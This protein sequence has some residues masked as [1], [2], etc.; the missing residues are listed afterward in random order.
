[1]QL[2]ALTPIAAAAVALIVAAANVDARDVGAAG[3]NTL[4]TSRRAHLS[5]PDLDLETTTSLADAMVLA[6]VIQVRVIDEPDLLLR[7]EVT[8][9]VAETYFGDATGDITVQYA[10]GVTATRSFFVPGAP[11]LVGGE[12]GV[13][14]LQS[15]ESVDFYTLLGLD[16]GFA[17]VT[18]GGA[19]PRVQTAF[20]AETATLDEFLQESLDARA[21][22]FA[23]G[24]VR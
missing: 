18:L 20:Q 14:F 21:A 19:E 12:R 16:R 5:I 23:A 15:Y 6:D 13:F 22:A 7:T 8:L 11:A 3:E 17:P 9:R 2:T 10:G 4:A 1:M 24:V